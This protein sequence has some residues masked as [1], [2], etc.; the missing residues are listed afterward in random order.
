ML[1]L[2]IIDLVPGSDAIKSYFRVPVNDIS[3]L[4]FVFVFD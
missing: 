2:Q 3:K 4:V 1:G